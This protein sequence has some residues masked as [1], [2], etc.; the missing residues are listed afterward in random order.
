MRLFEIVQTCLEVSPTESREFFM[1]FPIKWT[2]TVSRSV[3]YMDYVGSQVIW[4]QGQIWSEILDS[5]RHPYQDSERGSEYYLFID[6]WKSIQDHS[7]IPIQT[8]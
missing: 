6:F 5:W 1:S 2:G 8:N 3:L 4:I 7:G